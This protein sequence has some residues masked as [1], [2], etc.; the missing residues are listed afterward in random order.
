MK[1]SAEPFFVVA[2]NPASASAYIKG[3][4]SGDRVFALVLGQIIAPLCKD[5]ISD[6]VHGHIVVSNVG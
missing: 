4:P 6:G 5:R 2:T 1:C 3:G